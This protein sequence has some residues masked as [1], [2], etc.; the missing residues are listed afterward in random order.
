[1]L[2]HIVLLSFKDGV[3][4]EDRAAYRAAVDAFRDNPEVRA[5][6]LGENVGSGPNHHDF[7]VVIDFD[8]MASFRRYI[9][10]PMH[11]EYVESFAKRMVARLAAVQHEF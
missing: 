4:P 7:A 8:D 11:A 9:A 6:T 10:S 2:R 3:T 5:L 1:M